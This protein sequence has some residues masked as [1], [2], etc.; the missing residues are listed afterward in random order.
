MVRVYENYYNMSFGAYV[1]VLVD[2]KTMKKI[3]KLQTKTMHELKSILFNADNVKI[4]NWSIADE[5]SYKSQSERTLHYF[6]DK[7]NKENVK[8]HINRNISNMFRIRKEKSVYQ[9]TGCYSDSRE[10]AEKE[11]AQYLKEVE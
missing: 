2:E 9:V 3:A 11:H 5:P 8:E 6:D 10:L 7:S 1:G 4:A